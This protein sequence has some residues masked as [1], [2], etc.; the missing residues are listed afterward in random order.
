MLIQTDHH[1]LSLYD[2]VFIIVPHPGYEL[3]SEYFAELKSHIVKHPRDL[4]RIVFFPHSKYSIN[5]CAVKD[6]INLPRNVALGIV[7]GSERT[8]MV[9][10]FLTEVCPGIRVLDDVE[11]MHRWLNQLALEP[12]A[13]K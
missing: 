9:F 11:A 3:T 10:N 1:T 5:F 7:S 6:L 13:P 12:Q 2:N 8:R 4:Y